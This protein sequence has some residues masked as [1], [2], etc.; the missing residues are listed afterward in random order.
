MA[1][2]AQHRDSQRQK[3]LKG[4]QVFLWRAGRLAQ[5][6]PM[7]TDRSQ[8]GLWVEI[9]LVEH[10]IIGMLRLNA[11]SLECCLRKVLEVG[12][13]DHVRTSFDGR[14]KHVPIARIG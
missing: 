2:V 6:C 7:L 13:H 12:G 3:R 1:L 14:R 9:E 10:E 11:E 5:A 8:R 4:V